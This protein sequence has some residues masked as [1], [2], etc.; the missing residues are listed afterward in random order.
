MNHAL[1]HETDMPDIPEVECTTRA[2]WRTWLEK[3]HATSSGVWL[4]TFKKAVADK[5]IPYADTVEESL[6]FGW[7]DSKPGKVDALRSKLYFS[8]RKPRS[9]WAKPNKIRIEA[10]TKAGLMQPA[11]LK[12]VEIAKANGTWTLLDDIEEYVCPPDLEAAMKMNKT[13]KSYFDKF[14]PGVKKTIYQ[15][16][17][18]AKR[19]ETRLKRINETVTLAEQNIR[20]NQY[21]K[22]NK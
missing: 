2:A 10:L 22:P 14:P 16:I 1:T 7:V 4:I 6:C 18:L 21:R 9:A 3:H 12:A 19:P 13:A 11:G 8:P 15:W 20:A 5:H 17:V